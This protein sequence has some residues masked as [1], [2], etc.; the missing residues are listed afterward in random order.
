MQENRNNNRFSLGWLIA[1][2]LSLFAAGGATAWLTFH[3]SSSAPTTVKSPVVETIPSAITSPQPSP[4]PVEISQPNQVT[5][6]IT[7]ESPRVYW[8]KITDK[9]TRLVAQPLEVQKSGDKT[10]AL[11][12]AFTTLLQGSSDPGNSTMLPEGTKLLH[13]KADKTGVK[14]DLSK[15]FTADDGSDVLIGRLAQVIYTATSLDPEAKVW[16]SVGGQPLELLGES[17]GLMID[18]PMTRKAFEDNFQ[19]S[20]N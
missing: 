1:V 20:G 2:G 5:T 19:L 8:L 18:Q 3:R 11:K 4:V 10:V 14:L 15:E 9:D 16:I 7:T 13:I 12:Q 17:H 6:P